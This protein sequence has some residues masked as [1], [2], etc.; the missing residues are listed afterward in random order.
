MRRSLLVPACGL[1]LVFGLVCL[2]AARA[3]FAAPSTP[4]PKPGAALPPSA[5]AAPAAG[6]AE[7]ASQ[8]PVTPEAG[9]WLICAASYMGADAPDL[10]RQLVLEIRQRHRLP[11]YVF[12][13]TAEERRKQREEHERMQ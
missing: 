2:G 5:P 9:P 12:D 8:Y 3:Q 7:A 13:R 4:P 10:A 1:A 6:S 11:A